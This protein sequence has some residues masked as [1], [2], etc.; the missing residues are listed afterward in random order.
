MCRHKLRV[1]RA[2]PSGQR[3]GSLP[4][5]DP[6]GDGE[7]PAYVALAPSCRSLFQELNLLQVGRRAEAKPGRWPDFCPVKCSIRVA[8]KLIKAYLLTRRSNTSDDDCV[9]DWCW[10]NQTCSSSCSRG[11]K[12]DEGSG[13]QAF[14]QGVI[15]HAGTSLMIPSCSC[16]H[17]TIQLSRNSLDSF[18][19]DTFENFF[20]FH[21]FP[22]VS[23]IYTTLH[24][25]IMWLSSSA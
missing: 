2:R 6:R 10:F 15:D 12:S 9:T 8:F 17:N 11:R 22:I 13:W 14:S 4:L 25:L 19:C 7:I 3:R 24:D 5:R 18:L 16:S 20:S 23:I 1:R 21:H